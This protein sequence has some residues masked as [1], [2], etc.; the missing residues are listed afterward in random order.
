MST[1]SSHKFYQGRIYPGS[2]CSKNGKISLNCLQG[3]GYSTRCPPVVYE[4]NAAAIMMTNANKPNSRTY[5]IDI[6][7]FALQEWVQ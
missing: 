2:L 5:H 7:Y 6:S 3:V 1:Y 4:D